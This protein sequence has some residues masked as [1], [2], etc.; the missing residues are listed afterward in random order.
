MEE[1]FGRYR[2]ADGRVDME[3]LYLLTTG[4]RRS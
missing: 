4:V 2:T 1:C 3:R